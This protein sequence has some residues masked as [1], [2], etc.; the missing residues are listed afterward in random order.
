MLTSSLASSPVT[1]GMVVDVVDVLDVLVLDVTPP[2]AE[3]STVVVTSTGEPVVGGRTTIG[4]TVNAGAAVIGTSGMVVV[5]GL[6]PCAP[7]TTGKPIAPKS[8]SG[9][10][11]RGTCGLDRDD[12]RR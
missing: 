10:S 9:A 4:A 6:S 11:H 5:V 2:V 12:A 8:T 7:T 3:G 1:I